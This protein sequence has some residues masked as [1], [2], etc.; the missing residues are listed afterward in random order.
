MSMK[1][2]NAQTSY[3][4]SSAKRS[5]M[6]TT[7]DPEEKRRMIIK[8]ERLK[9]MLSASQMTVFDRICAG[10]SLFFTG[11]AGTGKSFLL[12]AVVASMSVSGDVYVTASTGVAACAIGGTT[13][14]SFAGV[15]LAEES[16][17]TLVQKL[18]DGKTPHLRKAA[19]RWRSARLLIV[20]ECSM[21]DAPFF[22]KLD[23]IARRLRRNRDV[24]FGGLQVVLTGDF[25]QLPPVSDA[26]MVFET[27]S[28]KHLVGDKV[29][30]LT[31][32]HRQR[33]ERFLRMLRGLR[34]GCMSENDLQLMAS[35]ARLASEVPGDATMLYPTRKEADTVNEYKLSTLPGEEHIYDASDKGNCNADHWV[36]PARLVLKI[37]ALVMFVKNVDLDAGVCN[38]SMG[39]V[40]DF[41]QTQ[42]LPIVELFGA[43]SATPLT[44]CK[45]TW[46]MKQGDDV[47]ASRAQIPLILAWAITIHKSQGT[48]LSKVVVSTSKMFE[49]SQLYVAL[50]RCSTL[51]GLFIVGGIPQDRLMRPHPKVSSWWAL[52]NKITL[53]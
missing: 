26:G 9:S 13:L 31:E 16:V 5:R 43:K 22:S 18:T 38:G 28:W 34:Q 44:V 40:V 39:R 45:Q 36:A 46:E 15:G 53:H 32:A 21:I 25:F 47:V 41:A 51:E 48:T 42:G 50:S 4:A 27:E 10:E 37:G 2:K 12:E 20:D 3:V 11:E 19:S 1:R 23:E 29:Y 14:H 33:D 6:A 30:E 7:D 49:K 17:D 8:A 24:P 35:R 52:Q